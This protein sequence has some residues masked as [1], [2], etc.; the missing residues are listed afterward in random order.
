MKKLTNLLGTILVSSLLLMSCSGEKNE[1]TENNQK[2]K[3]D[4]TSDTIKTP[5]KEEIK[6]EKLEPASIKVKLFFKGMDYTDE[7]GNEIIGTVEE[8]TDFRTKNSYFFCYDSEDFANLQIIGEGKQLTFEIR[9]GN[10]V[11]F[12]KQNFDLSGKILFTTRDFELSMANKYSVVVKQK[13]TILFS[14]KIDSQ[15]CM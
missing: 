15:G 12:S 11:I 4:Q 10:K 2:T 14:G 9:S 8:R 6:E 13:E 5:K 3:P 7:E 1:K